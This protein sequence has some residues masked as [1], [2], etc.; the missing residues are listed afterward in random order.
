MR[1]VKRLAVVLGVLL[2]GTASCSDS[3]TPRFSFARIPVQLEMA[4]GTRK[5][6]EA[7]L[8]LSPAEQE[9]GLSF[10]DTIHRDTAM[11]FPMLPPRTASFW[12]K[13]TRA[14]LDMIFIRTDGRIAMIARKVKPLDLKP[15]S[16][17]TPVAGVLELAG[18][19]AD[20][21]GLRE[22]DR[23]SWGDCVK[24]PSARSGEASP[25]N[26]CPPVA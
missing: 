6:L 8:A 9:R 10:R 15:V 13:D 5:P 22:G 17:G 20:E 2:F 26:F 3:D 19:R 7:E 11:L 4:G 14:A 1:R 23:V 21:L 25:V 16:T 24:A 12:M 18:G